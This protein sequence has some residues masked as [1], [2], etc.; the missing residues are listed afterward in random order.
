MKSWLNDASVLPFPEPIMVSPE[1]QAMAAI[2]A[3]GVQ[4]QFP[5]QIIMA[6]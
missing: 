2:Q 3:A 5:A 6:A 4:Y 1:L